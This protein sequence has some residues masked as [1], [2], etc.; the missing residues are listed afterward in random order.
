MQLLNNSKQK[1]EESMIQITASVTGQ[2]KDVSKIVILLTVIAERW[3]RGARKRS[4][5]MKERM[6]ERLKKGMWVGT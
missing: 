5:Q 4:E 1:G 6:K 2:E 3:Q